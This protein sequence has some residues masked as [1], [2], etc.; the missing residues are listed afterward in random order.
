MCGE[1]LWRSRAT[2]L[3]ANSA[4]LMVCLSGCDLISMWVVVCVCGLTTYVSNVGF[5]VFWDPSVYMKLS[6]FHAARNGLSV[7]FGGYACLGR[8][9]GMRCGCLC[10]VGLSCRG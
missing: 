9:L 6:G 1:S 4:L 2:V 7:I 8:G 10:V 3:A 5:P